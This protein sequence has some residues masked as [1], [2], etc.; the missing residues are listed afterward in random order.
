MRTL[1]VV[2]AFDKSSACTDIVKYI[3][4]ILFQ[5]ATESVQNVRTVQSLGKEEK[6]VDLYRKSLKIPNRYNI[7]KITIRVR[8]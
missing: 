4:N 8:G 7:N 6:F 2:G 1:A 5:I 3:K